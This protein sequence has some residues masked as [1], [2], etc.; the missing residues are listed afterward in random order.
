MVRF[1]R[2]P[3]REPCDGASAASLFEI[4]L[5]AA[6]VAAGA[7]QADNSTAPLPPAPPPV[8][9]DER[10]ALLPPMDFNLEDDSFTSE[11]ISDAD[12]D[13]A[14]P[15]R[16]GG[17]PF[18]SSAPVSLGAFWAPAVNVGGQDATL[19]INSEFARVATPLS[20]P[21]EGRPLW[22]AIGKFGRLEFGTDVVAFDPGLVIRDHFQSSP[23]AD[24][25]GRMTPV[26]LLTAGSL[27]LMN[28]F[29]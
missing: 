5:I 3:G 17:P 29:V 13:A 27:T 4:V 14:A 2:S 9:N 19:A 21:A 26:G 20:V 24:F 18:G 8:R 23:A 16:R 11:P 7:A 6:A 22:L 12:P 25:R 28:T 1:P 10:I 15:R